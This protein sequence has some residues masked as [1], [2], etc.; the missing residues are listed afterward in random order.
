MFGLLSTKNLYLV[1]LDMVTDY[2]YVKAFCGECKLA[3]NPR[4]AL[5]K[6]RD[7]EYIDVFTGTKYDSHGREEKEIVVEA[8]ITTKKFIMKEEVSLLLKKLNLTYLETIKQKN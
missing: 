1:K 3:Y 2:R 7:F 8:M 4:F 5:A 6:K